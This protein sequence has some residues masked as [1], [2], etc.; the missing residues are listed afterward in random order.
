MNN[1]KVSLFAHGLTLEIDEQDRD[2]LADAMN[3]GYDRA[4]MM[5]AEAL[6]ESY[7][8]VRPEHVGALTDSPLLCASEDAHLNDEGTGLA[9]LEAVI[10]WYPNYMVQDPWDML[11]A[12][13][14]VV[15]TKGGEC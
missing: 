9:N 6:H 15:F 12:T 4:E 3:E 5:V 2:I 1:L 7:D 11:I 14:R 8:F 10:Y 13:G